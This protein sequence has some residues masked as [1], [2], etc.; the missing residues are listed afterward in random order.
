MVRLTTLLKE[1]ARLD[2]VIT[3]ANYICLFEQIYSLSCSNVCKSLTPNLEK[4]LY[5]QVKF[6]T[7]VWMPNLT[8]KREVVL[9]VHGWVV[10]NTILVLPTIKRWVPTFTGQLIHGNQS[11]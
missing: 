4:N 8:E 10:A 1:S 5:P 7:Q 6:E 11:A 3:K 9:G 2:F